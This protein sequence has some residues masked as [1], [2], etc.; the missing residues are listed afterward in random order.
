MLMD[1]IKTLDYSHDPTPKRRQQYPSTAPASIRAESGSEVSYIDWNLAP[2][3][4][5]PP[6]TMSPSSMHLGQ[7]LD[8]FE[9]NGLRDRNDIDQLLATLTGGRSTFKD[10]ERDPQVAA[11]IDQFNQELTLFEVQPDPDATP[12]SRVSNVPWTPASSLDNAML[13]HP[14]TQHIP[15]PS[16]ASS[17]CLSVPNTLSTPLCRFNPTTNAPKALTEY[18]FPSFDSGYGSKISP[19][20][21][22]LLSAGDTTNQ[23]TLN[24]DIGNQQ[25]EYPTITNGLDG[26]DIQSQS[27]ETPHFDPFAENN[28]NVTPLRFSE[29]AQLVIPSDIVADV[30]PW[31]CDQCDHDEFK[32]KS[33]FKYSHR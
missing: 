24:A 1:H 26:L 33:E 9:H 22:S 30:P 32:N 11:Q 13:Q 12:R 4:A 29:L 27:T 16:Y 14:M 18:N 17:V 5:H 7:P 6:S 28:P 2:S 15:N 3:M 8:Q 10:K 20:T 25:T 19:C 31:K 23:S 21:T